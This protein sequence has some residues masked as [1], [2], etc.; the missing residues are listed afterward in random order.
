VITLLERKAPDPAVATSRHPDAATLRLRGLGPAPD[1][2]GASER[3]I[4]RVTKQAQQI[5][6]LC[7][8]ILLDHGFL[9]AGVTH[10]ETSVGTSRY[11]KAISCGHKPAFIRISDHRSK[12]ISART[13]YFVI[14]TNRPGRVWELPSWLDHHKIYNAHHAGTRASARGPV[15]GPPIV[16]RGAN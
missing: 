1:P 16:L 10:H 4:S 3:G 12:G 11:I 2:V 9:P 13:R 8:R 5:E 14:H 15:S 6:H 7:Y